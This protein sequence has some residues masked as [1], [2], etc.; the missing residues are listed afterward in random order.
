[1]QHLGI[2]LAHGIASIS[3]CTGIMLKT[4]KIA[5]KNNIAPVNSTDFLSSMRQLI[6]RYNENSQYKVTAKNKNVK[7]P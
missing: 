5:S 7:T 1:M 2:G 3:F 4:S 6:Y